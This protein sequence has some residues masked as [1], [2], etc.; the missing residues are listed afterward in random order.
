MKTK[1]LLKGTM[2]A[3]VF[4]VGAAL[5]ANTSGVSCEGIVSDQYGNPVENVR[6]QCTDNTLLWNITGADGHYSMSGLPLNSTVEVI[7]P[8]GFHALGSTVSQKLSE[9]NNRVDFTLYDE[10]Y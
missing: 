2:V 1:M 6:V 8:E 7:V 10:S 5:F 9:Q 4:F 3:I